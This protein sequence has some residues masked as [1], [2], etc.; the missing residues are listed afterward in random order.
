[1]SLVFRDHY[2]KTNRT[3]IK[4]QQN[5]QTFR[6]KNTPGRRYKIPGPLSAIK[7]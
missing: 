4:Q 2:K 7:K 1:M 6:Q 3:K 5:Y